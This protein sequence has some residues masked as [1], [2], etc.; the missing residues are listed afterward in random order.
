[1][2]NCSSCIR[3][4]VEL[5]QQCGVEGGGEWRETQRQ[6]EA[7]RGK[8]KSKDKGAASGKV[9]KAID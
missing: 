4:A 3:T 8:H 1:M 6:R 5:Q 7:G 2:S 9:D